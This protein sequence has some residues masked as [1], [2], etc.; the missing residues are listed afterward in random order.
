MVTIIDYRQR[1]NADGEKFHALI[2][3]GGVEMVQSQETGRFY[4]TAKRASVTSTFD[5]DTCKGLKGT[6]LDGTIQRSECE[7]YEYTIQD[8]GEVI[9]LNHHWVYVPE[10][11][12][13]EEKVFEGE[14]IGA[15]L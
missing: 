13:V 7:S 15:E 5:E 11:E 6:K 3:Q 10:G 8:T 1:T 4:A 14:V 2:L 12:N 9:T